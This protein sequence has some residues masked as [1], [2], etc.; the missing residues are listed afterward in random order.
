[1]ACPAKKKWTNNV[2]HY[3]LSE[4]GNRFL[5]IASPARKALRLSAD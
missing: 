3:G 4:T 5:P 2:G 1:M